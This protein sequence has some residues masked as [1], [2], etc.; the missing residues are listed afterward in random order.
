MKKIT[1]K[2][3]ACLTLAAS[4]FMAGCADGSDDNSKPSGGNT[5]SYPTAESDTGLATNKK[6]T[7]FLAGDSTVKTYADNQFIGGWGQFFGLFLDGIDVHNAA[8][9][10][11]SSRSFINEGRLM[12]TG[13]EG[14]AYTFSENGGKSIE[15][16]IQEGDFLFVQF[17]H[18]DDET[19]CNKG[20]WDTYYDR[21][22]PLGNPDSK[23]IYPTV[24]PTKEMKK[25]NTYRPTTGGTVSS[26][27]VTK[28]NGEVV[29]YGANYYSTDCGGTYKGYLKMYIDFAR[30]KKAIPVLVTPVARVSWGSD[31][32]IKGGDGN[33]GPDFAYVKAMKQLAEEEG[34]LLIDNFEAT[35]KMLETC[36]SAS[37]DFLM[38]LVPNDLTGAWPVAYDNAYQ[39]TALGYQKMEGTHYNKFGA[40]LTA[41]YVAETIKN[42]TKAYNNKTEYFTFKDSIKT[43]PSSFVAA[44]NKLSK[45]K[46]T[47]LA[48]LFTDISVK[49]PDQSYKNPADVV[50]LIDSELTESVTADNYK[51]YEEKCAKCRAEYD[52]L[53][54]DDRAAVTNYSK[55]T[56]AEAAVK[57]QIEAHKPK[58]TSTVI[59]TFDSLPTGAIST[60]NTS[61]EGV[62]IVATSAKTITVYDT[63]AGK[64]TKWNG[65]AYE[66]VNTTK[67]LS[68]G[69]SASFGTYRY[70]EF[71][72]NA[73]AAVTIVAKSTG[74]DTR[75][76]NMVKKGSSTAVAAFPA[77]GS[78]TTTTNDIADAGTYQIGSAGSGIYILAIKVEYFD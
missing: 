53:N 62:S 2:F 77:E 17:G 76:V 3:F 61:V 68:M 55:L 28:F 35:K 49:D 29:K 66:D 58:P 44:P 69:G 1:R 47:E 30:S 48:A 64:V 20:N 13:E 24:V 18:N 23:G 52:S 14:F 45:T 5:G 59:Y 8:Q 32:K 70:V 34:V 73:N 6:P 11:R 71:S 50:A 22:V 16:E 78:V 39:N 19:Y 40:Y 42:Y 27:A 25:P 65:S 4:I 43:T 10:G 75:T 7:I 12:A 51:D 41:A 63:V 57:E 38:A 54:V 33:H 46:V 72:I 31:G 60:T 67:S 26:T 21:V 9:G 74:A 15:S 36:T 56:T 37:S